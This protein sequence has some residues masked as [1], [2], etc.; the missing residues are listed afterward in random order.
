MP[1]RQPHWIGPSIVS[2]QLTL[3]AL[4]S[5]LT[6]TDAGDANSICYDAFYRPTCC[7][8]YTWNTS[9]VWTG[10][11]RNE[12]CRGCTIYEYCAGGDISPVRC[13]NP[14]CP[15]GAYITGCNY[16]TEVVCTAC[17]TCGTNQWRM[18]CTGNSSGACAPCKTC[19]AGSSVLQACSARADTICTGLPCTPS[20]PGTCPPMFCDLA[21]RSVGGT[22][23]QLANNDAA[24]GAC[25]M[26]PIGWTPKDA[27]CSMCPPGVSCNEEGTP[28][29]NGACLPGTYPVCAPD[30]GFVECLPCTASLAPNARTI[31]GGVLNRPDTCNTYMDCETGY[32]AVYRRTASVH[33]FTLECVPCAAYDSGTIRFHTNGLTMGDPYSCLY[34]AS[35]QQ[36]PL[37]PSANAKGRWGNLSD[38]CP[39]GYTSMPTYAPRLSDCIPCPSP[40][41]NGALLLGSSPDCGFTCNSGYDQVGQMCVPQTASTCPTGFTARNVADRPTCGATPLPWTAAGY[42]ADPR[43][44]LLVAATPRRAPSATFDP[45]TGYVANG[46]HLCTSS[47][48]CT[49]TPNDAPY[50]LVSNT[51]YVYAF[52]TRGYGWAQRYLMIQF[53]RSSTT[54]MPLANWTTPRRVCASAAGTDGL[55]YIQLCDTPFVAFLNTSGAQ[56]TAPVLRA[57]LVRLNPYLSLLTGSL[58]ESGAKDGMRDD[59]RFEVEMSIA[60]PAGNRLFALMR[61]SGRLVEVRVDSPGSLLT[62]AKTVVYRDTHGDT[63]PT[64][65]RGL[66]SVLDGSFLLFLSE[67]G[68]HQVDTTLY[69]ASLIAA[70]DALPTGVAWVDA[71][72]ENQ[73]SIHLWNTTTYAR[74]T[75]PQTACPNGTTS[76]MGATECIPCGVGMYSSPS[77]G[78]VDCRPCAYPTACGRGAFW[79]P[80]TTGA[81]ASCV[82]CEQFPNVQLLYTDRSRYEWAAEGTCR[83]VYNY[84]CPS[85]YWG[86]HGACT[87]C[88]LNSH[89]PPNT[90]TTTADTCVCDHCGHYLNGSC[91]VPSPFG[92]TTNT[93]TS[94]GET[95]TTWAEWSGCASVSITG[96]DGNTSTGGGHCSPSQCGEDTSTCTQCGANGLYLEQY[97][98]KICRECPNGTWG[99]DGLQCTE[100]PPFRVS[101]PDHTFCMCGTGSVFQSPDDCVCG[102]GYQ[103]SKANGC[104]ICPPGTYQAKR[105]ILPSS[106]AISYA[107]ESSDACTPC[108]D[109]YEAP[110]AGA[111]ACTRCARGWYRA[112]SMPACTM[113]NT[114]GKYASDPADEYSCTACQTSCPTGQRGIPCP[115]RWGDQGRPGLSIDSNRRPGQS[116]YVLCE[117]CPSP[118]STYRTLDAGAWE[119]TSQAQKE[120]TWQCKDS[121]H[122]YV[123]EDMGCIPCATNA[124][125]QCAP[126]TQFVPCTRSRDAYCTPC[127]NQTMPIQYAEWDLETPCAWQCAVGYEVN[128]KVYGEWVEYSCARTVDGEW[129]WWMPD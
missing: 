4:A 14:T 61:A 88:P 5:V 89:T 37:P 21:P 55:V 124:S 64:L 112:G 63:T 35:A 23:S 129:N 94:C 103:A 98:P 125:K 45:K 111:S 123:D 62:D 99:A 16:K 44:G 2:N 106:N 19:P 3:W 121:E 80:C 122:F 96:P 22:W 15:A 30:T 67:S 6:L 95:D 116:P 72:Q 52:T 115:T 75:A 82:P 60:L 68:L 54:P 47:A 71:T 11:N 79:S 40:P 120:C 127:Q 113:C 104:T 50:L 126:G 90:P 65:P 12:Q 59:A 85:G 8:G 42:V 26:C 118:S 102:A 33:D 83:V 78:Q 48:A 31:R 38:T 91:V 46:T 10:N 36:T 24:T 51:R 105:I 77:T 110:T 119:W 84:P 87:Q 9:F 81:D 108:P 69:T 27:S 93:Q 76:A 53:S 100:C 28:S 18:G 49:P 17:P 70:T 57:R 20:T 73:S 29:C 101:A 7:Y 58:T 1:L 109:G 128:T 92:R 114:P 13:V 39:S 66:T 32:V 74:A 34:E 117:A 86:G 25:A 56:S 97:A 43:N 41:P 107:E